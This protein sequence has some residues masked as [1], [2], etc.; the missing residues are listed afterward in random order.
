[1]TAELATFNLLCRNH[2]KS[3]PIID[4]NCKDR[5][6]TPTLSPNGGEG[7]KGPRM[8]NSAVFVGTRSFLQSK[9]K[10][11]DFACQSTGLS[12]IFP[13]GSNAQI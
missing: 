8:V 6:L 12:F 1:M 9:L 5:P 3:S 10:V 11:A 4:L 2:E 13:H 7:E